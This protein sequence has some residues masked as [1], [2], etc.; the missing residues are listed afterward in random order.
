MSE[1]LSQPR[2]EASPR[3]LV[4][5]QSL[6]LATLLVAV[7][8]SM[9]ALP[10]RRGRSPAEGTATPNPRILGPWWWLLADN[11]DYLGFSQLQRSSSVVTLGRL[12]AFSG[13][14][15]SKRSWW[16]TLRERV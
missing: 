7:V 13:R 4:L 11:T 14:K 1:P 5:H 8:M 16:P 15:V 9:V 3:T 6:V 2:A 10:T 12:D